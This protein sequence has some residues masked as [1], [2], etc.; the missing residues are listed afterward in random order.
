MSFAIVGASI[1]VFLVTYCLNTWIYVSVK[2]PPSL[3]DTQPAVE[4]IV[5]PSV[6]MTYGLWD[7]CFNNLTCV[8]WSANWDTWDNNLFNCY[9]SN[10]QVEAINYP[11]GYTDVRISRRLIGTG[12]GFIMLFRVAAEE[13]IL[14]FEH[15]KFFK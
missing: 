6:H 4:L 3:S 1:I 11:V 13:Y 7:R 14:K 5:R 9:F 12:M 10:E 2:C 15:L 8:S